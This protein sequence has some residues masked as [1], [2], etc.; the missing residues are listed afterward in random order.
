MKTVITLLTSLIIINNI[1]CKTVEES[2][3]GALLSF[4]SLIDGP[5][6]NET[7]DVAPSQFGYQKYGGKLE[8]V[9]VLPK[10]ETYHK[11]C[12]ADSCSGCEWEPLGTNPY[13]HYIDDWFISNNDIKDYI[14]VIDRLDCYFVYKILH[15]Q[16]MGASGVI[17]CDWL[18]EHLFT[19]WMPQ[20]WKDNINIPSV[21][22]DNKNCH[23]LMQHIG[24][25]NWNPSNIDNM[26]YPS[27]ENINWT[28]ATIEWGLPHPDDRVEY[29]LWTSSNDYLGSRFK[30]NFNTTAILLDEAGDTQF[31][32]HMYIL[33]GSHWGCD[34]MINGT[35][36]LTCKQQCT[37]NG[38]Y[39][40][41][42]PEYD[43]EIGLDGM[44]VIQENLR[45]L[46]V[47]EYDKQQ[48]GIMDD[49][50]WWDYAVLWDENCGVYS[51]SSLNF[52]ENCSFTQMDKLT[53]NHHLSD[54][55]LQKIIDTGGYGYADGKNSMLDT[56]TKLKYNS[57]IYAVPMIRVNEFLIHGNIDCK[58]PVTQH[59]CSVL[60]AI[61]A[62]FIEGTQPDLCSWTLGSSWLGTTLLG[63]Y[64]DSIYSPDNNT[65]ITM[66]IDGNLVLY[67]RAHSSSNWIIKWQTNSYDNQPDEWRPAFI[68]QRDG[69]LVVYVNDG[70]GW[71][72]NRTNQSQHNNNNIAYSFVVNNNG[73]AYNIQYNNNSQQTVIWSTNDTISIYPTYDHPSVCLLPDWTRNVK[74]CVFPFIYE[75]VSFDECT[76]IGIFPFIYNGVLFGNGTPW[77][78][79]TSNYDIDEQLGYCNCINNTYTNN[80]NIYNAR[81]NS[82]E[83]HINYIRNNVIKS[84]VIRYLFVG[85]ENISTSGWNY[86]FASTT[87]Y[88]SDSSWGKL[89]YSFNMSLMQLQ[90]TLNYN[91]TDY[92]S[93]K[94]MLAID[95]FR[96]AEKNG[97]ILC[98]GICGTDQN[99]NYFDQVIY[100]YQHQEW[101]ITSAIPGWPEVWSSPDISAASLQ[102]AFAV[103]LNLLPSWNTKYLRI[104]GIQNTGE[105]IVDGGGWIDITDSSHSRYKNNGQFS[106][107]AKDWLGWL[108]N[109]NIITLSMNNSGIYTINAYD[110]PDVIPNNI[111]TIN[112]RSNIF[113]LKI[114]YGS[115]FEYYSQNKLNSIYIYYQ[116]SIYG[117]LSGA[118]IQYCVV[119]K[120]KN[121]L[122]AAQTQTFGYDV[123]LDIGQSFVVQPSIHLLEDISSVQFKHVNPLLAKTNLINVTVLSIG[124]GW[125]DCDP[126]TYICNVNYPNLSITVQIDFISNN[127]NTNIHNGIDPFNIIDKQLDCISNTAQR[128]QINTTENHYIIIHI[129]STDEIG[130]YGRGNT[131]IIFCSVNVD[132]DLEAYVFDEYPYNVLNNNN[133]LELGS[134]YSHL[135]TNTYRECNTN[136]AMNITF[137]GGKF[138]IVLNVVNNANYDI[139][140]INMIMDTCIITQ[141][142]INTYIAGQTETDS[143][144]ICKRCPI[145]YYSLDIGIT[146]INECSQCPLHRELLDINDQT[147]CDIEECQ[148]LIISHDNGLGNPLDGIYYLFGK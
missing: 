134:I 91:K 127:M 125:K 124:D 109:E 54:Y 79:T 61:C 27:V 94:H 68:I 24:V 142:P 44:D 19:M 6:F 115:Q 137:I 46:C 105:S 84:L 35:Y 86:S 82:N 66:Q 139:I 89:T 64:N 29:E 13:I 73:Y 76:T 49:I 108:E 101:G 90:G 120:L 53:S 110:R 97:Y 71:A 26:K 129:R 128:L 48:R 17:M 77:C 96:L 99:E 52:H 22:L 146:S 126:N 47:W 31:T 11:E 5:L 63:I 12:P 36:T 74:T 123:T 98:R 67:Y 144:L 72:T 95:A 10:N 88:F 85:D 38:R 119:N 107:C 59:T 138:Y 8:A 78:A 148:T 34:E 116:T 57:S 136:M 55:V 140:D 113:A 14:L 103:N 58:P 15:A 9:L 62:E 131:N 104:N 40:A 132:I 80:I 32:P 42:D 69:N 112:S 92:D 118:L 60:A 21:L 83:P 51:N 122:T 121:S 75:G 50:M 100:I 145:N 25:Q 2:S 23:T 70:V 143:S 93:S 39:C 28:I 147:W 45:S 130:I 43:L 56:E 106:P 102:W 135:F 7:Y 16:E 20:D 3:T 65:R 117:P 41:V 141:C 1:N 133:D 37:N 114:E 111:N 4:P 33:N 81:I 18:D 87:L 30:H